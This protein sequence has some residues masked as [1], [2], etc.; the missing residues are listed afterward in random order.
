MFVNGFDKTDTNILVASLKTLTNT[1]I[2]AKA[3]CL[4]CVLDKSYRNVDVTS[5]TFRKTS[6]VLFVLAVV[7]DSYSIVL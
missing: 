3:Y 4:K 7:D 1:Y 5:L 6:G 2:W